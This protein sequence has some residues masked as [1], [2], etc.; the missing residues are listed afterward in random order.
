MTERTQTQVD[1]R[2]ALELVTKEK[3]KVP[4]PGAAATHITTAVLDANDIRVLGKRDHRVHR[5]VQP[6]VGG[7]TVQHHRNWREVSDLR[8]AE[9]RG[10]QLPRPD[11]SQT[12]N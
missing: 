10:G 5:Q 9:K 2:A 6:R 8:D 12:S 4:Q 3:W 11:R 1:P 7:D